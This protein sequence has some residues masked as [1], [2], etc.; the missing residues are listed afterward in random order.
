M[1]RGVAS[2]L[3]C[4][5]LTLC[6]VLGGASAA[7][8]WSNL[9]LQL[10][11]VAMIFIALIVR[12][13][14]SPTR[15][16]TRLM[17]LLGLVF[18]VVA[19]Q[20]LPLPPALWTLLPGREPVAEG[21]RLLNQPLPWLPISLA[22]HDTITSALWLLPAVAVLLWVLRHPVKETWLAWVLVAMVVLS[23]LIGAMQITGGD[24]SPWYFYDV[25][26]YGVTVGFFANANHLATLLL[27]TVPFLGAL[28]L[29]LRGSGRLR[30]KTAG[31]AVILG[32]FYAVVIVGL[33]INGSLAGLGLM[34]PVTGATVLLLLRDR[35]LPGWALALLLLFTAAS[36]AAVFS[37]RF[38]NNLISEEAQSSTFSRYTTFTV[39]LDAAKDHLPFGSGVGTFQAIYRTYEDPERVTSMYMNHVH[40]DWIE[41]FLETGLLGL[42]VIFLFLGWWG[43][44]AVAIWRAP[45]PDY[46]GRAASIATAAIIAHSLVDYPLRTVA[47]S[48]IFAACCALMARSGRL[49]GR[50]SR[51]PTEKR[52]ARHLEAD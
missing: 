21:F 50:E 31:L 2:A 1:S 3:L 29:T 30:Q 6:L 8:L 38:D 20:L 41:L 37:G 51:R 32:G 24:D 26:N 13:S 39:S 36:V 48:A 16:G 35:K 33:G 11:A 14:Q 15:A 40:S 7:G 22:P 34:V 17:V 43:R 4:A 47:I 52:A 27:A 9:L 18:G 12:P 44:R 23:V 19:V 25:T 45:E 42:S 10:L 46:F 49:L 5:Y 28:Y